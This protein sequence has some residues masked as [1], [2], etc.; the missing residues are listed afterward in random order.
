MWA[1]IY[2]ASQER[3]TR[4][5]RQSSVTG[6][7]GDGVLLVISE[8]DCM[9]GQTLIRPHTLISDY[10]SV[11]QAMRTAS[12]DFAGASDPQPENAV[13]VCANDTCL[14]SPHFLLPF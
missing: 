8:R 3:V 11:S 7:I 10:P 1:I 6:K 4:I 9:H 14:F 5:L 2:P 12:G 13:S